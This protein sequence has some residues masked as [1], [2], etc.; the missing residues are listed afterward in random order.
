MATIDFSLAVREAS[1][2]MNE[3]SEEVVVAAPEAITPAEVSTT[4]AEGLELIN[5]GD[6]S[7]ASAC[8][9]QIV[10]INPDYAD[11]QHN[12]AN[13]LRRAGKTGRKT[14]TSTLHSK[15]KPA[16]LTPPR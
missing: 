12:L 11:A 9:E 4:F 1:L 5:R 13:S 15:A 3:P 10:A 2:V 14:S 7:A 8:F 6:A 16:G